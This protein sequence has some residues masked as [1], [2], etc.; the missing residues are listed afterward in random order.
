MKK[1]VFILAL[2]SAPAIAE[3]PACSYTPQGCVGNPP[4]LQQQL[5]TAG[6]DNEFVGTVPLPGTVALVGVGLAGLFFS[7]KCKNK[8]K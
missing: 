5:S 7:R 3:R 2:L 1:M 6:A 8:G 4:G